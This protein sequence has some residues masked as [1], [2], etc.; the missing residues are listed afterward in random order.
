MLRE[1]NRK[2]CIAVHIVQQDAEDTEL[3]VKEIDKVRSKLFNLHSVNM[4]I[5]A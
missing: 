3:A 1:G 2:K 5:V 4:V